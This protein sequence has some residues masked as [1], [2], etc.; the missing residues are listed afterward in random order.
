MNI[1]KSFTIEKL[2]G[3]APTIHVNLDSQFNFLIGR[4]GTGKTTVINLLA[5]V[6]TA[7]F[8]RLDRID[9]EKVIVLFKDTGKRRKNPSIEVNKKQKEGLPYFDINY[10]FRDSARDKPTVFDLDA[11]EQERF[12]RG[13]P[14]RMIRDRMY[15][16]R[17]A[18]LR[19]NLTALV[20]TSWLSVHRH[21]DDG[22]NSEDR[23]FV[24]AIDQKLK[25]LNIG[26]IR[27]FSSLSKEYSDKT[28]DFQRKT[29]LS[30]LTPDK[31]ESVFSFAKQ[32]DLDQEKN[33]LA[34]IF[35]VLGV[36][37]KHYNH[38]LRNHFDKLTKAIEQSL[39]RDQGLRADDYTTLYGA[40]KVHALV[41]DYEELQAE[42][43]RIF[44]PRDSF[45]NTLNQLFEG[46]K[47]VSISE[48]NELTFT[49]NSRFAS[50][51]EAKS[52]T[53]L[54]EEL[55]SGEKQLLIILGEALLQQSEPYVYIAD[56]PELSLH[57]FWQ[58]EL[59][60]AISQLN[61][62]AQIIFAT[63]SP[64]IVGGHADKIIDMES[65]LA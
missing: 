20:K 48:K 21:I 43:S 14:S 34:E 5:A 54:P 24:P 36:D 62:N 4:N 16:E 63:H 23:R 49:T 53:I 39:M 26:L 61:R 9:F 31:Q 11:L 55:S 38:K 32:L 45:L 10:V 47:K 25:E 1:I 15:R 44:K 57:V 3:T 19:E 41:N 37:P 22:R 12:Y 17:F 50:T 27:Y 30:V 52:K 7:D 65:L 6:L 35:N 29:F 60:T 2:W 59:T 8:D 58:E 18:D 13:S 51:T 40:W 56:E 42:R 46:K 28:L 64:D 33:T